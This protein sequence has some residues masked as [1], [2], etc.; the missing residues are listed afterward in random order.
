MY[1]STAVS[2]FDHPERPDVVVRIG[3]TKVVA[4]RNS[5]DVYRSSIANFDRARFETAIDDASS[6]N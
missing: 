3:T 4:E 6:S 1:E 2:I 5:E